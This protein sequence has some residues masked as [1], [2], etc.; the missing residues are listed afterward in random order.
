MRILTGLFLALA[1]LGTSMAQAFDAQCIS[2]GRAYALVNFKKEIVGPSN[3]RY[4]SKDTCDHVISD[5]NGDLTCAWNTK[6]WQPFNFS[7]KEFVGKPYYGYQ[8]MDSCFASVKAAKL[9]IACM[10][11]GKIYVPTNITNNLSVGDGTGGFS[12]AAGCN[13]AIELQKNGL[14]C[15]WSVKD[16]GYR[17]Y[18]TDT[19]AVIPSKFTSEEDCQ[20]FTKL[21]A[22]AEQQNHIDQMS[23][24]DLLKP[25]T[26]KMNQGN[27]GFAYKDCGDPQRNYH[28][29]KTDEKEQILPACVPD[30]LYSWGSYEKLTWFQ[31]NMGES[32]AW[33]G[34]FPRPLFT[35]LSPAGTFGYGS[36]AIRIKLKPTAKVKYLS[37]G[38]DVGAKAC[39]NLSGNEKNDT[40]LVRYFNLTGNST[41]VDYI[42]CSSGPI[43]SWSFGTKTHYDEVA[44]EVH[45]IQGHTDREY[46]TYYKTNGV[47]SFLDFTIDGH[48]F[49]QENL[50]LA[51]KQLRL[52]AA[53]KGGH[54]Y[55][56]E[57]VMRSEAQ[58]FKTAH[59]SYFNPRKQ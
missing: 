24:E 50:L 18:R 58:H 8:E 32:K 44:N 40:L 38:N 49:N 57:G 39:E 43:E 20:A 55:Y 30:T 23:L 28:I 34:N 22:S 7:T 56:N 4:D 41:G 12:E 29:L 17:A 9:G 2:D 21:G 5:A 16:Q 54:V 37:R 3:A 35:T 45:W 13:K 51:L 47:D 59:P 6:N 42:L 33:I 14:I 11:A 15:N 31:E 25:F 53:S 1:L 26:T 46:E 52:T 48:K 10:W 19:A 27:F 36:I